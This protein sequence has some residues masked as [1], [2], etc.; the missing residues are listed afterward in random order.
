[1]TQISN[2]DSCVTPE[3]PPATTHRERAAARRQSIVVTVVVG[4]MIGVF[5][6][7]LVPTGY[8]FVVLLV[9][10][11]GGVVLGLQFII[12]DPGDYGAGGLPPGGAQSRY[13]PVVS[14]VASHRVSPKAIVAGGVGAVAGAAYARNNTVEDDDD[15]FSSAVNP[16]NGLP[17]MP[18]GG[19]DVMGNP[20]G[21]DMG[22]EGMDCDMGVNPAN[23]I[24][25][26]DGGIDLMGNAFGTDM[27]SDPCAD[28]GDMDH[29]LTSIDI[30]MGGIDHDISGMDHD[31]GSSMFDDD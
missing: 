27:S 4:A 9:M 17:M 2:N 6:M 18:G 14:R 22:M 24:P 21:T 28:L 12:N 29:G 15:L 19:V 26:L 10:L 25:M 1:M 8:G 13:S 30:D 5:T 7:A 11:F 31:F 20:F 16:A 23:G 3:Q